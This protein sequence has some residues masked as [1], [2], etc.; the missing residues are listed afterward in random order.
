MGDTDQRLQQVEGREISTDIAAL[1][2]AFTT[3]S[4]APWI[5]PREPHIVLKG[6]RRDYSVQG[7]MIC[8]A[9]M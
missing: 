9:A 6:L 3:A 7:A 1:D 5:S 4:I 2:H 8:F